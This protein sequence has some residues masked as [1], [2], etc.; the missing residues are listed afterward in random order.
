MPRPVRFP[1]NEIFDSLQG[2]GPRCGIRA[3][4]VRFQ[5]CNLTCSWCDTKESWLAK[6]G[7]WNWVEETDLIDRLR[8]ARDLILTGGE[9]LLQPLDRLALP[10]ARIHVETNGTIIPTRPLEAVL[11]DGTPLG[12]PALREELIRDWTWVVSPKLSNSG[13]PGSPEALAWWAS[14]PWPFFKFIAAG[15][16]DLEEIAETTRQFR[17]PGE[18]VWVGLEGRTRDSQCRP[19]LVEAIISNG[20]NYSPR[21]HVILWGAEKGR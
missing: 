17:L 20:W 11:R 8:G 12:R 18:R 19:A 16:T 14:R 2:E 6:S 13:Q 9:P 7:A 4:F 1:V 5:F 21:L 10:G 3:R 15:P